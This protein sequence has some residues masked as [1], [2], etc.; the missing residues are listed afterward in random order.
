MEK[1]GENV[2]QFLD[3]SRQILYKQISL[4]EKREETERLKEFIVMEEEKLYEAQRAFQEDVNRFTKYL[5]EMNGKASDASKAA[6]ELSA[7][8]A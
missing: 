7:K 5:E 3:T 6:D 2:K 4:N 8:K 1:Q